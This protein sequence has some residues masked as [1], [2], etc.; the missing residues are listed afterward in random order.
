MC[1]HE[2]VYM[3]VYMCIPEYVHA[4]RHIQYN[5]SARHN[6]GMLDSLVTR[7]G[8]SIRQNKPPPQQKH[9]NK[10]MKVLKK[11][12]T[13]T[14]YSSLGRPDARF[15]SG[16]GIHSVWGIKGSDPLHDPQLSHLRVKELQLKVFVG[17]VG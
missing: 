11:R 14:M 6:Q 10:N 5:K 17:K 12:K 4:Y 3:H 13:S 9:P 8:S 7:H 2:Y 16:G 1:I 15:P